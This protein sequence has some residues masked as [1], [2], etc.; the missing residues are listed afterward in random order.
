M[1]V[2][3]E[4]YG[5]IFC[6]LRLVLDRLSMHAGRAGH[7][8]PGCKEQHTLSGEEASER[9]R[10]RLQGSKQSSQVI[11]DSTG[12]S[13]QPTCGL[14]FAHPLPMPPPD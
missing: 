9:E 13:A 14:G 7:K 4:I 5:R 2:V 8:T 1:H 11:H 3:F 6:A 10:L 12:A